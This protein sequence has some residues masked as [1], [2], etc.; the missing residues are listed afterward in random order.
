MWDQING[1]EQN[2][3]MTP[4]SKLCIYCDGKDRPS[5]TAVF[6]NNTIVAVKLPISI[7][8]RVTVQWCFVLRCANWGAGCI[9]RQPARCWMG[10]RG[11]NGPR[12]LWGEVSSVTAPCVVSTH[13]GYQ[14]VTSGSCVGQNRYRIL[15]GPSKI[16]VWSIR[17]KYN[18][19]T[20]FCIRPILITSN[21]SRRV[22]VMALKTFYC[23]NY[24]DHKSHTNRW[25][26]INGRRLAEL[27][28]AFYGRY[29]LNFH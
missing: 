23:D 12:H 13:C 6:S 4:T 29:N 14:E 5:H 8:E 18:I 15:Y 10:I 2:L 16:Y 21:V 9:Y 1:P 7:T 27:H 24:R 19:I 22:R 20:L 17:N 28:T 3:W 25:R 26:V 11:T